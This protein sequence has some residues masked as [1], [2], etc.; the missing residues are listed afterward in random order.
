MSNIKDWYSIITTNDIH[1][2]NKVSSRNL[3]LSF[4][5]IQIPDT[6]TIVLTVS[7]IKNKV[8]KA[9]LSKSSFGAILQK[10]ENGLKVVSEGYA[11]PLEPEHFESMNQVLKDCWYITLCCH[12]VFFIPTNCLWETLKELFSWGNL[13]P[14][15]DEGIEEISVFVNTDEWD[16]NAKFY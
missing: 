13:K 5:F 14:I 6:Q 15:R 10:I 4:N 16:F 9:S 8:K 3:A 7:V 1:A 11:G 2:Q 12:R